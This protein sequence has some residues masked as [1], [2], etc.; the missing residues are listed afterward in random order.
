MA[1]RDRTDHVR[2]DALKRAVLALGPIRRGSLVRRF[3]P[4]GKRGCRCQAVPPALHGPYYQWTRKVDGKTVT[5][6]LTR[7]DARLVEGWISNAR[8]L[9]QIV[10]QMEA[11]SF[12]ITQRML[13]PSRR[14]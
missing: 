11:I 4:C 7:D 5:I 1:P 9:D 10:A 12:R 3:M 14:S 6:R 13:K 8:H 2:Y